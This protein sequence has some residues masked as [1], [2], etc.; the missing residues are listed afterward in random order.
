LGE[1]R[2]TGLNEIPKFAEE[3]EMKGDIKEL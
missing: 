3:A 1:T 2:E